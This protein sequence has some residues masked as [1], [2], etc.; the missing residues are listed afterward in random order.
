VVEAAQ[1]EAREGARYQVCYQWIREAAD[2]PSERYYTR[3]V[4]CVVNTQK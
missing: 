3:S 4:P 2:P 1:R